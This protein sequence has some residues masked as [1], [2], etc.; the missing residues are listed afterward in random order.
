MDESESTGH[1]SRRYV[2]DDGA[3]DDG[4]RDER[5]CAEDTREAA[6]ALAR[7]AGWRDA[8][9]RPLHEGL[10]A[11]LWTIHSRGSASPAAVVK[12]HRGFRTGVIAEAAALRHARRCGL[13][14]VP[15][16]LAQSE[17][18]LVL[19]WLHPRA[20]RLDR[21]LDES[22]GAH[23]PIGAQ[24]G[25]W[26]AALHATHVPP[27]E[28]KYSTDPLAFSERLQAQFARLVERATKRRRRGE[29]VDE[30]LELL[31]RSRARFV[32]HADRLA[33]LDPRPGWMMHRDLRA[34][35]MVGVPESEERA[36]LAG[37]VDF[38]RA[39]AGDPAWDFVKLKWWLFD[40]YPELEAPVRTAYRE[41]HIAPDPERV[42]M[43]AA[44]EAAGLLAYF[45]GRHAH[46][47]QRARRQL[48][49]WCRGR[50][51]PRW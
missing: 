1:T 6:V 3:F 45:A 51:M 12:L 8:S 38:E 36:R 20:R 25:R 37:V 26:L 49:A 4:E 29:F 27:G 28:V 47:P 32:A 42:C 18:G 13:C 35:N 10:S 9:L 14:G 48:R 22:P 19:R 43:Y 5:S 16:V 15:E 34:E 50:G 41:N 40:R 39:G 7:S 11:D 17:R 23:E 2:F 31:E 33:S 30:D 24:L 21:L 44:L 46:Y